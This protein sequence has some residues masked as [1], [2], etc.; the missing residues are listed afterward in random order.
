MP[1]ALFAVACLAAFSACTEKKAAEVTFQV[2]T[3]YGVTDIPFEDIKK[4]K[5][6]DG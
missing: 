3:Q 1:F 4:A 6:N 2:K 5:E